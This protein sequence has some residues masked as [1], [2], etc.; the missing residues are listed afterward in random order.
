MEFCAKYGTN[1]VDITGEV[2]WHKDMI[3]EWD[4]MAQKTGAKVISFCGHDCIPWDL[5]VFKMAQILK[6]ECQDDLV[7][8]QCFDD[9]KGGRVSGGTMATVLFNVDGKAGPKKKYPF[10]PLFKKPDGSKSNFTVVDKPVTLPGKINGI[11]QFS[12]NYESP[13]VMSTVNAE[14]VKRSL[15]IKSEGN[16]KIKYRESLYAKDW[17]TAFLNWFSLVAG[18]TIIFTPIRGWFIPKPG[19]GPAR[20]LME[21]GYLT[22]TGY[23]VGSKGN[24]VESLFYFPKEAGYLDTARM[25]VE[26]GLCLALDEE[27]LPV[28]KGGLF[29]PATG[30]GD[31]LMDRLCKTGSMFA[32]KTIHIQSK[33]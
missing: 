29:T 33:L 30:M 11:D 31:A 6:K 3:M 5:S 2:D 26:S 27:K 10:N 8:V 19:E 20:K 25:L 7:E 22:V 12:K 4:D 16:R 9:I 14:V 15:A 23:G 13:F 24:K 21:N 32:A 18:G 1:Y 17:K 28:K